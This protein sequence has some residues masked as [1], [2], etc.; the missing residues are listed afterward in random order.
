VA[1]DLAR[2]APIERAIDL[3]E[4]QVLF[5]PVVGLVDGATIGYE[6]LA[7]LGARADPPGPWFRLA[8]E[9]GL[10]TELELMCL[11]AIAELGLP[12][13]D[14]LLFVNVSPD[15]L[16][17]PRMV[18]LC[19]PLANRLVFE[20]TEHIEVDDYGALRPTLEW[21]SSRGARLAVDDTGAGYST[22]RHV[23]EL[24]PQYLKLDRSVIGGLDQHAARRSL[25]AA[26]VTFADEVGT[27]VIA[28]GVERWDEARSLRDV[29]VHLAQGFVFGRPEV[30]WRPA[31]WPS[32]DEGD[33]LQRRLAAAHDLTGA[34]EVVCEH[35]VER[36]PLM[37]SVYL[38]RDGLLRC[39]AQRGCWQVL[40]GIPLTT[41]VM[42]RCFRDDEMIVV[43]D[44]TTVPDVLGA[45]PDLQS[46]CAVPLRTGAAVVGVLS[47][48]STI[49]LSAADLAAVT[50]AAGALSEWMARHSRPTGGPPLE[51]LGRSVKALTH[52]TDERAIEE[53]LVQQ[54][55]E[56]SGMS[57]AVLIRPGAFD[58]LE[59][60]ATHGPLSLAFHG[61]ST[62]ELHWLRDWVSTASST[63]TGTDATGRTRGA[64][65]KLRA[66]GIEA[67]AAV[68]VRSVRRGEIGLLV[69]AHDAPVRIRTQDIEALEL[70]GAEAARA[71][72]L[73]QTVEELRDRAARDPLTGLG[74]H[75]SFREAV[76]TRATVGGSWAVLMLDLDAFKVVNDTHG[77]LEGDRVLRAVAAAM[78]QALG[79][80]DRVFR[81]GG[82]EFA[83]LLVSSDLAAAM[84]IRERLA[85]AAEPALAP[86]G[87]G[88]SIGVAAWAH[89]ESADE[90]LERAQA[91]LE[92]AKRAFAP[93]P[94]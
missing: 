32:A 39:L 66:T 82:D 60:G 67:V 77:H 87:V 42:A 92:A 16:L 20:L 58:V 21:W 8:R 52:L 81:V 61:L 11:A 10:G 15:T 36:V 79:G 18:E 75:R 43:Q 93:G 65:E 31:R 55:C 83:A 72:D 40:D 70:L 63:Y 71:L 48:E 26:L 50:A 1:T 4:V 23:L 69:L 90:V 34:C 68:P 25:V 89:P 85:R 44:I 49:S 86:Y 54:A 73:A 17:H 5:Q 6:A 46:Q 35:L 88:M 27:T 22:L 33:E 76:R 28:E 24:A 38:E 74:N 29:G 80:G 13:G 57:S 94:R 9:L 53:A 7:R 91:G 47:V 12:P 62:V 41:G 84:S 45:V 64:T 2:R 59:R 3:R 14:G 19:G 56:V 37:P 78:A 51:R 30:P